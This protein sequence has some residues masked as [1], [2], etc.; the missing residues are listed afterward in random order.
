MRY[1]ENA[2]A[3][4]IRMGK[5][6]TVAGLA[7]ALAAPAVAQTDIPII[8]EAPQI[9][10]HGA[11]SQKYTV[12]GTI[13]DAKTREPIPFITVTASEGKKVICMAQTDFNGSFTMELS[14]GNYTLRATFVGYTPVEQKLKVSGNHTDTIFVEMMSMPATTGLQEVQIV[15]ITDEI[16]P[17]IEIG[18]GTTTNEQEGVRVR[19]QY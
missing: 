4:R 2:L 3:S 1:L 7:L 5:V 19:V 16:Y 15:G 17:I 9:E 8:I 6:A 11:R 12:H 10:V 14:R 13:V 18:D